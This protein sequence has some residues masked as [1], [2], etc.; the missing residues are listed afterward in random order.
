M[1]GMYWIQLLEWKE[2]FDDLLVLS[3]DE[4]FTDNA[5]VMARVYDFI[6]VSPMKQ[7]GI[8]KSN[9][10]SYDGRMSNETRRMLQDF[11]A[12]HNQMLARV[13]GEQWEGVWNYDK[14]V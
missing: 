14:V 11:F 7:S 6:G 10:G 13:L 9:K 2:L 12:P 3:Y 8:G 5:A 4:L 1:R